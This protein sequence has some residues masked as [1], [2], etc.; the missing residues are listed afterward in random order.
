MPDLLLLDLLM[1]EMD[2]FEVLQALRADRRAV[3]L[4][5]LVITGKDLTPSERLHIKSRMATLVSKREASLEY[6]ARIV[7]ETLKASQFVAS[8]RMSA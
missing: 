2:G 3:N 7:A 4:P 6:F 5:V 1:P 8:A